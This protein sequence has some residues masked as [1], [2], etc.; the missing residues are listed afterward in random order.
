MGELELA[1]AVA[2]LIQSYG[3]NVGLIAV[4]IAY[5]FWNEKQRSRKDESDRTERQKNAEADRQV[6]TNHLSGMIKEN[7][8]SNKELAVSLNGLTAAV[9]NFQS[10][11]SKIQ[12]DFERQ[13]DRLQKG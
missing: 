12:D 13:V 7:S 11:C 2:K 3:I 8:D 5:L 6:L 1:A 10:R 4:F 9:T